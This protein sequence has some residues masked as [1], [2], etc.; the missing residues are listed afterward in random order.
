MLVAI[1]VYTLTLY[2][3]LGVAFAVPFLIAGVS[4]I[5]PHAAGAGIAFRLLVFPGVAALWPFLLRRWIGV[6]P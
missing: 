5:D 1:F 3:A 6:R 2:A 4:R